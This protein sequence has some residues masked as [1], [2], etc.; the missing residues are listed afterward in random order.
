MSNGEC[1]GDEVP[2]Q[3]PPSTHQPLRTLRFGDRTISY[4]H[5]GGGECA[6]GKN[7]VEGEGETEVD[8]VAPPA[9]TATGAMTQKNNDNSNGRQDDD[10]IGSSDDETVSSEGTTK[11]EDGEEDA[12][13]A[14]DED[15]EDDDSTA[16]PFE[17][18]S[19]PNAAGR[20]K[21]IKV[22]K[23]AIDQL[24]A[25]DDDDDDD[26]DEE[27]DDTEDDADRAR[28]TASGVYGVKRA[29]R[30]VP[31]GWQKTVLKD[32]VCGPSPQASSSSPGDGLRR[33]HS[34]SI[35]E[36][37]KS[38]RKKASTSSRDSACPSS[39][40]G[41]GGSSA[42]GSP[43]HSRMDGPVSMMPAMATLSVKAF[44]AD[45]EVGSD[46]PMCGHGR[47]KNDGMKT[48]NLGLDEIS[49]IRSAL[50][51]AELA[52]IDID[53]AVRE[54]IENGR[55]CF[56]CKKARF[57]IFSRGSKCEMCKQAVCGKCQSKMRIPLEHFS[58]TPVFA[59][60]PT[61]C[62]SSGSNANEERSGS[63]FSP[64]G[65]NS[66]SNA[67][68][69]HVFASDAS[70]DSHG[71]QDS[72]TKKLS[73]PDHVV[74]TKSV[75]SAPNSP[76]TAKRH[77]S[78]TTTDGGGNAQTVDSCGIS[79]VSAAVPM[80]SMPPPS[81]AG[82]ISLPPQAM[83]LSAINKYA[84]MPKKSGRRM[85]WMPSSSAATAT[86]SLI[87]REL[88]RRE[89]LEGSL[90]AVCADCKDMVLQVIRTSGTARRQSRLAVRS[91]SSAITSE[92]LLQL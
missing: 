72:P 39:S 20:R 42:S 36:S 34:I 2:P 38:R 28:S 68:T 82:P 69:T 64:S 37:G 52:G 61:T 74:M 79:S 30:K 60:S 91:A 54:D 73:L 56:L 48:L 33:R 81:A 5:E 80:A 4:D 50:T 23:S 71:G 35:C 41:S 12:E 25:F 27:S 45:N 53:D 66:A 40:G 6:E 24:L 86:A 31:N 63:P 43:R 46:A 9:N 87:Q 17:A 18:D 90:L 47:R 77:S 21:V 7:N 22:D 14:E 58:A 84:T 19:S 11:A 55:L 16:S 3:Q 85:S 26:E 8:R 67:A 89:L 65:N 10:G 29:G 13:A 32:L 1:R 49:H 44:G 59:L 92:P 83:A 76:V 75:G 15:D 57:G 70:S 78:W 51:K 88:D 62:S